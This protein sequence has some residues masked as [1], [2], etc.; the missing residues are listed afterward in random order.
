[1]Y[2]T[3]LFKIVFFLQFF[4][5]TGVFSSIINIQ[6]SLITNKQ[7]KKK[8]PVVFLVTNGNEDTKK[9]TLRNVYKFTYVA[10]ALLWSV[11][12][13]WRHGRCDV[14]GDVPLTI[15][16][17]LTTLNT[18]LFVHHFKIWQT[19]IRIRTDCPILSTIHIYK[20]TISFTYIGISR[21]NI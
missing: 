19:N 6:E 14:T 5:R 8:H 15:I 4:S 10:E 11:R 21:K 3:V 13:L 16:A 9:I 20:F 18:P 1:M 12:S 2:D 17:A 7:T